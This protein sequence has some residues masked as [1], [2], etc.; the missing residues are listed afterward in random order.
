M[1]MLIHRYNG[2]E[3]IIV[4]ETYF[5]IDDLQTYL[6]KMGATYI[7]SWHLLDR[8]LMRDA[9][10]KYSFDPENYVEIIRSS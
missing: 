8:E 6:H 9:Y 7:P 2:E 4:E 5:P 1:Y 10:Y 3:K